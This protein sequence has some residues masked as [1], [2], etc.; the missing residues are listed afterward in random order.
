MG[1]DLERTDGR[2]FALV[3]S[4]DLFSLLSSREAKTSATGSG[5][6]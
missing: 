1:F 5:C 2:S 3:S 4:F 6:S